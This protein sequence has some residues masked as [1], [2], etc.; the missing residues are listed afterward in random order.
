MKKISIIAIL[1]ITV[2]SSC[3][4]P[5]KKRCIKRIDSLMTYIDSSLIFYSR[6][7]S[8][9]I[10]NKFEDYKKIQDEA[11]TYSGGLRPD[12]PYWEYLIPFANIEKP[13]RKAL[14]RYL[15]FSDE[16][17]F[18]KNQLKNL[19]QDVKN[20]F[21]DS[22]KFVDYYQSENDAINDMFLRIKFFNEDINYFN[23]RIDTLSRHMKPLLEKLGKLPA[24]K[25]NLKPPAQEEND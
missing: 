17:S 21:I 6:I 5:E 10:F 4:G 18:S 8:A 7:D 15:K 19:R 23:A 20:D 12:D 3:M 14:S 9:K 22:K 1:T 2:F 24:S 25:V 13:Y 11:G 16:I